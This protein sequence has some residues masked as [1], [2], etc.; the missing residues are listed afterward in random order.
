M[1]E[2]YSPEVMQIYDWYRLLT[3]DEPVPRMIMRGIP[4]PLSVRKDFKPHLP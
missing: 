4:V 2:V 3:L 1:Q